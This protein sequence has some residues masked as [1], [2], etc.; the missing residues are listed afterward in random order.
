MSMPGYDPTGGGRSGGGATSGGGGAGG[1][2]TNGSAYPGFRDNAV[3]QAVRDTPKQALAWFQQQN[4]GPDMSSNMGKYRDSMMAQALQAYLNVVGL[5]GVGAG[6]N[7]LNG[8]SAGAQEFMKQYQQGG[9]GVGNFLQQ[10]A[11]QVMNGG[12]GAKGIDFS[13]MNGDEIMNVLNTVM[14]LTQFG[15]PTM[16]QYGTNNMLDK[17]QGQ[18][19]NQFF[20]G[21]GATSVLAQPHGLDNFRA[22]IQRYLATK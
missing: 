18:V 11:G 20:N 14:G 22:L 7:A 2:V 8:S 13:T 16:A 9:G 5:G 6:Q 1:G 21:G 15:A 12:N 10:A 17:L 3:M 19:N 4:G